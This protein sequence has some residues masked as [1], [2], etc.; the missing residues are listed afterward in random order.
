MKEKEIKKLNLERISDEQQNDV[1]GGD[2]LPQICLSCGAAIVNG[3]CSGCGKI[4]W[5][6]EDSMGWTPLGH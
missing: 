4:Y 3:A 6:T 5:T 1:K 2:G